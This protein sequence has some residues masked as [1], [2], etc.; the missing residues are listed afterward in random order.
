METI[1]G[2]ALVVFKVQGLQI[3]NHQMRVVRFLVVEKATVPRVL[4]YHIATEAV[5]ESFLSY[6]AQALLQLLPEHRQ[7][8]ALTGDLQVQQP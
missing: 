2:L 1:L 3:S 8:L 6:Q 7:S 5:Y 4:V